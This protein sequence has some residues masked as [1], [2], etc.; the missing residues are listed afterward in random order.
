MLHRIAEGHGPARK[1]TGA[2]V[3]ATGVTAAVVRTVRV[4]VRAMRRARRR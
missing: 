4:I 3:A 2:L 1:A